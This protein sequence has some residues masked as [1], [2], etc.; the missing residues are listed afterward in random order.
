MHPVRDCQHCAVMQD[1]LCCG[2]MHYAC[3]N[4]RSESQFFFTNFTKSMY[5]PCIEIFL[6]SSHF[7][8]VL[9]ILHL[10]LTKFLPH[11]H[12][13]TILINGRMFEVSYRGILSFLSICRQRGIYPMQGMLHNYTCY[14][15]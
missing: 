6:N 1:S 12:I 13:M 9:T 5:I 4:S 7:N 2:R 10:S 3:E 14:T 11:N 8:M 15:L